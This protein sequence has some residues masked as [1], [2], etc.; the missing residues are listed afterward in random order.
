MSWV[1]CSALPLLGDVF[2]CLSREQK[3]WTICLLYSN[4][5]IAVRKLIESSI[6]PEF[7]IHC[8]SVERSPQFH[9]HPAPPVTPAVCHPAPVTPAVCNNKAATMPVVTL[10]CIST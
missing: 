4:I 2:N 5:Y 10:S 1:I 9:R 6:S 3:S 8:T 7:M